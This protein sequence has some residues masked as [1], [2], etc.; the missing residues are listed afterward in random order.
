MFRT[1]GKEFS[2]GP[3]MFRTSS[4]I[5]GH[6]QTTEKNFPW[7]IHNFTGIFHTVVTIL[8]FLSINVNG[9][10][11][12]RVSRLTPDDRKLPPEQ[13]KEEFPRPLIILKGKEGRIK[14]WLVTVPILEEMPYRR[15]F[16]AYIGNLQ[17]ESKRMDTHYQ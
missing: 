6:S 2:F 3:Q 12:G 17:G 15:N 10:F 16:P 4:S 14:K 9:Y 1:Y 7:G 8:N 13:R 11:L 5:L